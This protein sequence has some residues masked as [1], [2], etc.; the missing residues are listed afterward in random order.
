MLSN[1]VD[2]AGKAASG[3]GPGARGQGDETGQA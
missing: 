1:H 3:P 2:G